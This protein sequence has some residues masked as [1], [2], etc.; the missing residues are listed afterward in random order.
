MRVDPRQRR[1]ALRDYVGRRHE[2]WRDGV[3]HRSG[4][5]QLCSSGESFGGT[6]ACRMSVGGIQWAIVWDIAAWRR[7]RSR[8]DFLLAKKRF[9]FRGGFEFQS[10]RGRRPISLW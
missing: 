3:P 6:V 8:H 1:Y 5:E 4:W 9:G 7:L 10:V 2:W